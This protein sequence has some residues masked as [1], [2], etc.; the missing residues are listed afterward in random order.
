M[1]LFAGHFGKPLH[2]RRFSRGSVIAPDGR[3]S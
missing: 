2:L 3:G 1:R